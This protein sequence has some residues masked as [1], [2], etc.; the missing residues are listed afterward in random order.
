MKL[1]ITFVPFS[2]DDKE[3]KVMAYGDK[4]ALVEVVKGVQQ[5]NFCTNVYLS[6]DKKDSN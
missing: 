5:N 4:D 1:N 6:D 2:G 3:F